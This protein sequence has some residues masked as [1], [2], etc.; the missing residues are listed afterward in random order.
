M[1]LPAY[2][3]QVVQAVAGGTA[4]RLQVLRVLEMGDE[5]AVGQALAGEQKFQLAPPAAALGGHAEVKAGRQPG[6]QLVTHLARTFHGMPL[7]EPVG[8]KFAT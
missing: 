3:Q 8:V 6:L 5:V 7:Y 2:A 1:I 4:A